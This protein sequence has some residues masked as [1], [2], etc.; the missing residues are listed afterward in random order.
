MQLKIKASNW[1]WIAAGT[2]LLLFYFFIDPL[3]MPWM[4]QCVFHKLTGLQCMGCGAQRMAHAVLHGNFRE[5]MEANIFLFFSLPFLAFLV[6]VELGRTRFPN[7][8][9]RV[10]S[11]WVMIIISAMLAAWLIVRNIYSI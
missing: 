9:R 11:V 2:A 3:K 8:Y 6:A 4:P 1:I 5:A 10:H 7:L